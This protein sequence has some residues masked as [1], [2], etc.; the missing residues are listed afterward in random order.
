[1]VLKPKASTYTAVALPE[2]HWPIGSP[3]DTASAAAPWLPSLVQQPLVTASLLPA[4]SA[5]SAAFH[6]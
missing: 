1:V 3:P 2:L 4:Y 5:L 6:R